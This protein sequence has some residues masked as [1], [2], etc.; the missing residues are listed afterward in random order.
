MC[1]TYTECSYSEFPWTHHQALADTFGSVRKKVSFLRVCSLVSRQWAG[2]QHSVPLCLGTSCCEQPVTTL[3]KCLSSQPAFGMTKNTE[4]QTPE[5]VTVAMVSARP[6]GTGETSSDAGDFSTSYEARR[7]FRRKL[8]LCGGGWRQISYILLLPFPV[9]TR[10]LGCILP[11]AF[12]FPSVLGGQARCCGLWP[13][14]WTDKG[15]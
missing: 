1:Q 6:A 4:S 10:S 7:G 9:A 14:P 13:W 15:K 12:P 11:G 8:L 5:R 2:F 3:P